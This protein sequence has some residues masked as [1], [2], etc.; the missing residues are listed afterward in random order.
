MLTG[1][2]LADNEFASQ[3]WLTRP[4]EILD[5]ESSFNLPQVHP[6]WTVSQFLRQRPD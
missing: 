6:G 4:G 2:L 1:P 5:T 3:F